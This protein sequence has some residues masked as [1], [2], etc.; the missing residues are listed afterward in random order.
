MNLIYVAT[1]SPTH[2]GFHHVLM[3]ILLTHVPTTERQKKQNARTVYTW[4][5]L[6][7]NATVTYTVS[8][9]LRAQKLTHVKT[10]IATTA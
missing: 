7:K 1:D 2:V 9:P 10:F 5:T 3:P 6:K 8:Q 4:D